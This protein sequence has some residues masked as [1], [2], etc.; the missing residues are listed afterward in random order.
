MIRGCL[1]VRRH[2]GE[3]RLRIN[4][5]YIFAFIVYDHLCISRRIKFT[6]SHSCKESEQSKGTCA[7]RRERVTPTTNESTEIQRKMAGSSSL[8]VLAPSALL[9]GSHLPQPATIE[10]DT[11]TGKIVDVH[12]GLKPE[13][14][15]GA[16]VV[17]LDKGKILLPGLIE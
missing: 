7:Q 6:V 1:S 17:K 9:P 2:F 5:H 15:S 14:A 10:I 13:L 12:H 4:V 3:H 16:E 11:A 8:V